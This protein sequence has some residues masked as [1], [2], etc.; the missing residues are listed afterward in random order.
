VRKKGGVDK[1]DFV[2]I[3][4]HELDRRNPMNDNDLIP[5]SKSLPPPFDFERTVRFMSY[6]FIMSP[7]QLRWFRFLS[8]TFPMSKTSTWLPALKRVSF[9]QF[10]FAPAGK[11]AT[12]HLSSSY[13]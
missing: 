12:R 2:A 7:L 6:G 9:D 11:N 4:I 10:L 13:R 3:E 5:D 1:D 8:S